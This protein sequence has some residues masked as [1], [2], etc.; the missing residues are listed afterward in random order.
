MTK[1]LKT[2][3]F[4]FLRIINKFLENFNYSIKK[5]Q[6]LIQLY[7]YSSYEEYKEKQ[8]YFNKKKIDRV[9]ADEI[10]LKIV[11]DEINKNFPKK[12]LNGICHGTRNGF[13][14]NFY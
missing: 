6:E 5:K 7:K 11:I 2:L 14:Q 8:T 12:K 10:T 3:L 4:Y 1:I 13:E 9:F